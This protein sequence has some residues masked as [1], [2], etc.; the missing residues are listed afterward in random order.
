M[1]SVYGN[2]IAP[3]NIGSCVSTRVPDIEVAMKALEEEIAVLGA[4]ADDLIN[5]IHPILSAQV[6]VPS[7]AT[8]SRP[9]ESCPLGS[10]LSERRQTLRFIR[11]RLND[12]CQR[13]Q[14]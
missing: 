11:E 4:A 12:A 10:C 9:T 3:G 13:V 2:Q 6:P 1:S 8:D 7:N 5:R 14:V